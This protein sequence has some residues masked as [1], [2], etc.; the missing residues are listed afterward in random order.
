VWGQTPIYK[1]DA[2]EVVQ[3]PAEKDAVKPVTAKITVN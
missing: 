3:T 2:E 1:V